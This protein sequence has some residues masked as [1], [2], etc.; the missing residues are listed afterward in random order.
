MYNTNIMNNDVCM[1]F[2]LL[3]D[4]LKSVFF[5]FTLC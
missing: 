4:D 3:A 2:M 1:L 5:N